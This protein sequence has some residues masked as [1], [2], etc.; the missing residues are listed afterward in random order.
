MA[1]ATATRKMNH[2]DS[3][4]LDQARQSPEGV[5]LHQFVLAALNSGFQ[6]R[7]RGDLTQTI[8]RSLKRLVREGVLHKAETEDAVEFV[9]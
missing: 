4:L 9:A 6:G 1:T 7:E 2:L 8:N 5:R 3:F